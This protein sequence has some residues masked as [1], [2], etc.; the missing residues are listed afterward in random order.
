MSPGI[1]RLMFRKDSPWLPLFDKAIV[2]NRLLLRR[3]YNKYAQ[4]RPP[5]TCH[6]LTK[7]PLPLSKFSGR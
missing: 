7:G 3:I 5:T 6:E 1:E 4:Y 2:D